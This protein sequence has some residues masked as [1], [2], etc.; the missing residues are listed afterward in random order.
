MT[1]CGQPMEA[2]DRAAVFEEPELEQVAKQVFGIS[3]D[4]LAICKGLKAAEPVTVAELAN[5][6]DYNR[7]TVSRHFDHLVELGI[8]HR[9]RQK[10][11]SGGRKYVYSMVSSEE[12]RR[13]FVLGLYAWPEEALQLTEELSTQK[14]EAMVEDTV[15]AGDGSRGETADRGRAN[16]SRDA[17][18]SRM[19]SLI[20]RLFRLD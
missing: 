6:F 4:E 12:I 14:V 16:G 8:V 20:R 11:R 10:L 1:C 2:F 3:P 13:T 15:V 7:S 19:S 5:R 17:S 9:E 18:E